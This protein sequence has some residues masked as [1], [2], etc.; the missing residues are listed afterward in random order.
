METIM[1]RRTLQQSLQLVTA[2]PA[3]LAEGMA[4]ST[5]SRGTYSQYRGLRHL[6]QDRLDLIVQQVRRD[7]FH[8]EHLSSLAK[9]AAKDES[10]TLEALCRWCR[11]HDLKV[12]INHTHGIC[13]FESRHAY[14]SGASL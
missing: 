7:G 4:R 8:I 11:F 1:A 2:H 13:F 14:R 12:S 10:E 3:P 9:G 6:P 5:A